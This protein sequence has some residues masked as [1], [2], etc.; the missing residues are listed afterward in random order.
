MMN[1]LYGAGIYNKGTVVS[2]ATSNPNTDSSAI[3]WDTTRVTLINEVAVGIP[4]TSGMPRQEIRYQFRPV[5]YGANSDFYLFV[6]HWK[7]GG[8]ADDQNRRNVEAQFLRSHVNTVLTAGSRVL[9]VGDMNLTQGTSEAAWATM[10]AAGNGQAIDPFGGNFGNVARTWSTTGLGS[11]LD[12]VMNTPPTNDGEGFSLINGSYH[13]F[14]NNGTTPSGGSATHGNNTALPGLPNRSTVLSSLTTA[15][16]HYPVVA[17]YRIP[18]KMGV[19]VGSV[20]GQV[21]VGAATPV[22]VTVTNAAPAIISGGADGLDYSVSGSGQLSGA[23]A[24]TNL[25]AL[26][27]GNVHALNFNTATPG[28]KNG[29]I[30]AS[31]TSQ[32]VADG[33]FSQDVSTTVLAHS[34][35]SFNSSTNVDLLPIDFGVRARGSGLINSGFSISNLADA[36]GFTAGLDLDSVAPSGNTAQLNSNVTTFS[37]LAP[38]NSVSFSTTFDTANLGS[39]STNYVLSVSDQDLPG[40]TAGSSL[41]LMLT[42]RVAIGGDATLDDAVNLNDFNV[43]A[44]NFGSTSG[45]WQTGDFTLDQLVNLNDFNVLAG[46]FGM[47]AGPGGPTPD[48]WSRL[49]S[50]VPE[51]SSAVLLLALPGLLRRRHG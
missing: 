29:T 44:A 47:T 36:S 7:A 41:A 51:P 21:I 48:D 28:V 43:L 50:L 25:M 30:N 14:G 31:S 2:G 39:F 13:T 10:T 5:G 11:R 19:A 35:A 18:A 23:G 1:S 38:G 20:P 46:N 33:S 40:A 42:G 6:G 45:T 37:N 34:D 9:Y 12:F 24:G 15:S 17:D 4:S 3:V 8:T 32:E 26:T 22:N 49:A 27:P 16:D